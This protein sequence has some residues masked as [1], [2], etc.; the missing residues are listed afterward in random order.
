MLRF[1]PV[2]KTPRVR[3]IVLKALLWIAGL[4]I[5]LGA[6]GLF[7]AFWWLADQHGAAMLVA[8]AI[9]S[10]IV[11]FAVLNVN[12]TAPHRLYR[13]RLAA[14]F[15]Q[16]EK[17]GEPTLP[18]TGINPA[19]T[20]PYH[21]INAA[22]NLPS[23]T[24]PALRDRKCD[25]FL[26]SKHWCGSPIVG[27]HE[28]VQWKTNGAPADLATA[29]AVSGAA[30]SSYMGLGSMPTLTAL[31][32]FLNVRLGFWIRNPKHKAGFQTPG[33]TVSRPRNVRHQDGRG[34]GVA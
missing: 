25:F 4:I 17:D 27:Y 13:D 24:N 19:N 18:L 7:Y 32:T 31:L 21:L 34:S 10:A 33:F 15:I 2:L 29:M 5:P 30:V 26:F 14:T 8:I 3:K 12:L 22:L 16:K 1:I 6:L 9:A 11:A 23:S 28:T 20:A